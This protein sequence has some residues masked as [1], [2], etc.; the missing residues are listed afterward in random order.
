[1]CALYL[2]LPA[3]C[4]DVNVS[5]TKNDVHFLEPNHVRAFIIKS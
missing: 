2:T 3:G 1:L 4:V 5:P